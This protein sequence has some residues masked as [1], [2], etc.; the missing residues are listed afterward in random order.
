MTRRDLVERLRL[1]RMEMEAMAETTVSDIEVPLALALFD[2]MNALQLPA[3]AQI[4]VLGVENAVRLR[5]EY[6][7]QW[8]EV[9]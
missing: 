4:Y 9:A 7:I 5:Q 1:L 2:V 8:E 3:D 6:G